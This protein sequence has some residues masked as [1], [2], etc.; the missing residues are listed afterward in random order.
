MADSQAGVIY[1]VTP[2]G[3]QSTV[4]SGFYMPMSVALDG[5][6]NHY[7]ADPW[8]GFCTAHRL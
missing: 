2:D 6:G 3:T 5:I 4:G 1:K 8:N 7:A